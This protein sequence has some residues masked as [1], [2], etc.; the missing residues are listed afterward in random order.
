MWWRVLGLE[1][2]GILDKEV[3]GLRERSPNDRM[4]HLIAFI[5]SVEYH[6]Q[7]K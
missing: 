3:L 1:A 2:K 5:F 7:I 6:S 4:R